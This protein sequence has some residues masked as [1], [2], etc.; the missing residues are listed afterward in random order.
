MTLAPMVGATVWSESEV[1][2][3]PSEDLTQLTQI[4]KEQLVGIHA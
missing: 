1:E 3:L 4:D 2:G